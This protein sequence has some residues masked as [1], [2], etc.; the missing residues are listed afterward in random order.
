MLKRYPLTRLKVDQS[1][2]RAMLASS[3]DAA[4]IE[5]IAEGVETEEQAERLRK[6]GCEVAQGFAS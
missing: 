1:F 4:I 6:K 2:V 5:V 3:E